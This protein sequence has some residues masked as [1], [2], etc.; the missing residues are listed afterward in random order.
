M[1]RARRSPSK[2]LDLGEDIF[3]FRFHFELCQVALG[4][5]RNA[6]SFVD[7]FEHLKR[8]SDLVFG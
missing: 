7:R 5:V 2:A 3:G 8:P 6:E 4:I 1:T